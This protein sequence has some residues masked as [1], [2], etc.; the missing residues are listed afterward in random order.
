MASKG[1]RMCM[2]FLLTGFLAT[3]WH[4][5][6]AVGTAAG[7]TITNNATANYSVA[8]VAA[9]AATS[10][11]SIRVDELIS[12]RVTAPVAATAVNTP[13]TNRVLAFTVSN[14]GNGTELFTLTPN[15]AVGGDQFNPTPGTAGQLF[16]DINNNGVLDVGT[17]TLIAGPITINADQSVRVLLVSNIPAALVNGNQGVVTLTAASATAGAAGAAPGTILTNLGTPTVGGGTIDAVVG[18]GPGGM[19]PV[20][21]SGSD[22]SANGTYVVAAVTVTI[23]KEVLSVTNPFGVV[24]G[25]CNVG[26]P[27]AGCSVFVPGTIVQYQVTVTVSGTGTAQAVTITDNIP[28]NSTYVANSIRVGAAARTDAVDADNASCSGCGNAVG[29]VAVVLGDITA[30]G[31]PIINLIDY[32]ITIN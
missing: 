6:H 32:R 8:G 3:S 29:T 1:L 2:A 11:V 17:D 26:A 23:V 30:A 27:P 10:T 14:V 20:P 13:D 22:D 21:D 5:A 12:V 19:V 25:P 7:T 31:V 28:V 4:D 24:S 18:V 16:L 9:T 15:L